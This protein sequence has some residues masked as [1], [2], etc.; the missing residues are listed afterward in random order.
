MIVWMERGCM[1]MP[2]MLEEGKDKV[3]ASQYECVPDIWQVH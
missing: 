3:L 1:S 2:R